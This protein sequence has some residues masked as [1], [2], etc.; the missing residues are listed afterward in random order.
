MVATLAMPR[1]PTPK[2][3]R[4]PGRTRAEK[5][6]AA[7]CLRTSSATFGSRRSGNFC[8]TGRSLGNCILQ[9]YKL[10]AVNVH[11]A[12]AERYFFSGQAEA[13][14]Q[15]FFSGQED[16]A[17]GANHTV[18]GKSF[19]CLQGPDHLAGCSW[20]AGG[21]GNFAISGYFA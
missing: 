14:F 4:A 20:E 15:P 16:F 19:G 9:E 5:P 10:A 8:L 1:L 6:A 12:A 17:A 3:I 2:A 21:L 13:L 7:N 11:P 18:P